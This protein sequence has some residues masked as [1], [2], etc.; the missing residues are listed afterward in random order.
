MLEN[1]LRAM[2]LSILKTAK[3]VSRDE[4]TGKDIYRV[5]ICARFPSYSVGELVVFK[6][7]PYQIIGTGR[8]VV[9]SDPAGRKKRVAPDDFKY[10]TLESEEGMIISRK[11]LSLQVMLS[12]YSMIDVR[13]PDNFSKKDGAKVNIV[14]FNKMRLVF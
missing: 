8:K 10:K 6:K 5:T 9:L 12:D 13:V 11:G 7:E 4:Q 2:G 1:E 3:N 14:T